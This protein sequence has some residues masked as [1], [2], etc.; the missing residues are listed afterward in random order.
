M[1]AWGENSRWRF[2]G[3]EKPAS[4]EAGGAE[5]VVADVEG[6]GLRV[7]DDD[8]VDDFDEA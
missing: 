5:G 3:G 1:S 7:T 6:V 2:A 8:V 4:D